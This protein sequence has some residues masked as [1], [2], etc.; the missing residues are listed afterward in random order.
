MAGI[1]I[2]LDADKAL[3][4]LG[5]LAQA[6]DDMTPLMADIGALGVQT[7]QDRFSLTNRAPDGAPWKP[8]MRAEA[9]GGKT[10]E[11]STRLRDSIDFEVGPRRVVWGTNVSYGRIH[12]TGGV[13]RPKSGKALKFSLPGGGF[14]VVS[15]VTMPARPYLGISRED[16]EDI[17]ALGVAYLK[18]AARP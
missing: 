4:G 6:G 15:K 10:L 17:R 5:G 1:S 3:A 9:E 18:K 8:S 2:R 13:I 14:A 11:K 16:A 7:T 12:Q